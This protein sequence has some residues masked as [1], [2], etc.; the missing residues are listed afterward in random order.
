M[1]EE[2]KVV[3][4]PKLLSPPLPPLALVPVI[5]AL[6][7]VKP[8]EREVPNTIDPPPPSILVDPS[9]S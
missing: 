8:P 4:N 2:A 3:Q 9:T 5:F 6:Y 1:L 7:W